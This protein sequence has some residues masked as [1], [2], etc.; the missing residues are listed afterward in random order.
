MTR[1]SYQTVSGLVF[2]LITLGQGI[3]AVREL[4]VQVGA[5]SIPVWVSWI[6][7]VV[8]GG[9]CLWAFRSSATKD[10]A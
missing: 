9:L 7:V 2:G 6:A 4:P 10:A 5:T 1:N 8:A 3:R